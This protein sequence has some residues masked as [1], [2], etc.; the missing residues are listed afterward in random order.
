MIKLGAHLSIVGGYTKALE[1]VHEIGGNCLQIFSS[2]PRSWS[3]PDL[4]DEEVE[5]FKT[6]KSKLKINP[7]YF[8]ASYLI[9]L[10][11]SNHIG[12]DSKK[13]LLADMHTASRFGIKGVV[14]HLGSYRSEDEKGDIP[15]EI[16][17]KSYDILI[18]NIKEVLEA[19]PN[20]V[21][22]IIENACT[23]KIG[24]TLDEIAKII[25]DINDERVRVCFDTCH[26]HAGGYNL[27]TMESLDQFLK[28]FDSFIGTKKMELLHMND[29][30]DPFGSHRDRHENIG[31]GHVGTEVFKL[32][33]NHPQ[34]KCLPFI[35]ETPGFD[36]K[37]PD[38]QNLDLLKSMIEVEKVATADAP[39]ISI[40][41]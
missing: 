4:T 26:L 12:K 32:L 23:H 34:T 13:S 5:K 15:P 17:S 40:N 24:M 29:S 28:I 20:D 1:K 39:T 31:K 25:G 9:N 27:S 6:L 10:A 8:H 11:D 35:I 41:L 3:K 37:G 16:I 38:K 21:L 30:K 2:S 14:A 36:Q 19:A 33:L 22:F 7:V 18:K